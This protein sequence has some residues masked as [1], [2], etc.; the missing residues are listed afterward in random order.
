MESEST[1]P[2][3][4]I[5]EKIKAELA[6]G[7][8]ASGIQ[9][10]FPPEPNGYLTFGHAKAICLNFGLATEFGGLCNLRF[11]DTNPEKEDTKFVLS[12]R[13]DIKWLGFQW[14]KETYASD[15]F[16]QLHSWA[17]QLIREGLAYVCELSPEDTRQYRGT[18][19]EPGRN[20]P[21]RERPIEENLDRFQ[22]MRAGE[23]DDGQMV[24]RAKI[25][26]SH[27][28]L[29]MRD[30]VM[31]RIKRQ[32]HHRTG[33]AWCIYPSYDYTHGQSDA[34][35][36]ITHSLCSLEFEAHRPLYDWFIEKLGIF[37]SRQTEF[38]RLNL[39]YTIMSKRYLRQL[40]EKGHVSDWDD[41][42]MPTLSGMRRRGIP[43]KA[44]RDFMDIIGVTKFN[45]WSD[46]ALL[47]HTIRAC[48]NPVAQ[49]RM[50][51]LDPLKVTI[52]NLPNDFHLDCDLPN[53]P[54]NADDGTRTVPFSRDILIERADFMEDAPKKFFRLKPG[55]EV[56]LRGS[57]VIRCEQVITDDDGTVSELQCSAD[58][59]TLGKNPEGRRVKGVIHW[60][61][62]ATAVPL[63]VH[64]Y[65]R[66]FEVEKPGTTD[67][68]FIQ[69]LNPKSL[70]TH[71]GFGEPE[72]AHAQP[73]DPI[74]FERTGYV[75]PDVT[76]KPDALVFNRTVTL[77]DAWAKKA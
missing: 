16:E 10:R 13:E 56:R 73:G 59:E 57:Y 25:D 27:P 6:D 34:I 49:R 42:R 65:E 75:T 66:L 58:L 26:M 68:D 33:D 4:F 53:N 69:E 37:P 2:T 32:H 3:H 30:P 71:Q 31:Y 39:T 21:W 54:E 41:P 61:N 74:Q 28:N 44:I 24:L 63:T 67:T 40:V 76:S 45:A 77:K 11:D 43:P 50:A 14:A 29:N 23:F 20:S 36:G 1:Q 55:G 8:H 9:T 64:C 35:E 46:L 60:V 22:R 70:V 18:L 5:R 12:M 19:T 52:T 47:E 7:K 38:S 62:A 48:L 72:L 15:Y 17:C 51:V